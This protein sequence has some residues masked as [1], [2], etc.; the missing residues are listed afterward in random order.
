[1]AASSGEIVHR[2]RLGGVLLWQAENLW[3]SGYYDRSRIYQIEAVAE[4]NRLADDG[5][6]HAAAMLSAHADAFNPQILKLAADLG[7]PVDS[8][9]ETPSGSDTIH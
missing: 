7:K 6:E 8:A 5:D 1:M 9:P 4:I 2:R 3:N